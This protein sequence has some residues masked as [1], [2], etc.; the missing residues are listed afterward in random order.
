MKKSILLLAV[1]LWCISFAG[2]QNVTIRQF[3]KDETFGKID[4]LMEDSISL[5]LQP[6]NIKRFDIEE[7]EKV[8]VHTGKGTKGFGLAIGAAIGTIPGILLVTYKR[9]S[10]DGLLH[11]IIGIPLIPVGAILGGIIGFQQGRSGTIEIPI[12]G[13]KKLY[14]KQKEKIKEFGY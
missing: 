1:I 5:L 10:F 12:M 9:D 7:V 13:N 3:S 6:Q 8:T 2:A 14:Q 4:S 11:N